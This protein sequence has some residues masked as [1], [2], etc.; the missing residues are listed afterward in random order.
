MDS[1]TFEYIRSSL[2]PPETAP[3]HTEDI[4]ALVLNDPSPSPSNRVPEVD[5]PLYGA[6]LEELLSQDPLF[7][8]EGNG[9]WSPTLDGIFQGADAAVPVAPVSLSSIP[10]TLITVPDFF[11]DEDS[12]ELYIQQSQE[13]LGFGG[14]GSVHEVVNAQGEHL[15]L[16]MPNKETP[17]E[18]VQQEITMLNR[19]RGSG[20][21]ANVAAFRGEVNDIRGV[22]LLFERYHRKDFW[23]L[24]CKRRRLLEPEVRYFGLQLMEGLSHIHQA[25]LIHCD[26][27]PNNILIGQWMI[28][29]IADFGLAE[30]IEEQKRRQV[31]SWTGTPGFNA[32]EVATLDVHTVALDI[33]SLGC[34]F[35]KLISGKLPKLTKY[36]EAPPYPTNFLQTFAASKD[37]LVMLKC[38]LERD[39]DDRI[40]LED[41]AQHSFFR[42]G[43]RPDVLPES[44]FDTP[45]A[46][47]A[48]NHNAAIQGKGKGIDRSHVDKTKVASALAATAE[49]HDE[50]QDKVCKRKVIDLSKEVK[51]LQEDVEERRKKLKEAFGDAVL[52]DHEDPQDCNVKIAVDIVPK[53]R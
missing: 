12:G 48:D 44:A 25:G 26:L 24:L 49:A 19:I 20:W 23:D 52:A 43:Y 22:G 2:L 40:S 10:L 8:V 39:P 53:E 37:A 7:E 6:P 14:F 51:E 9:E 29:K 33:F 28:L 4:S 13:V 46:F 30:D 21:H 38:A 17:A 27:K 41:L 15:T 35:Y 34:I 11:L 45:P 31:G 32:P 18:S 36:T 42:R 16:K 3:Q 1:I 47:P 50:D 5:S